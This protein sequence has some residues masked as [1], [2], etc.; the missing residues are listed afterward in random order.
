MVEQSIPAGGASVQDSYRR[1]ILR[2]MSLAGSAALLAGGS[3]APAQTPQHR[4][5][6]A[7]GYLNAREDFR[8]RGDGVADDSTPLQRAIDAGSK[9]VRPIILPPGAYRISRPLIIPPNTMLLG[10][11]PG[12]GFGCRLEPAGCAALLIGGSSMTF[13]CSIENLMIWPRGEP[14]ESIVSIDNSYSVTFRNIRIHNTQ[15]A[16]KRAAVVLLGDE[17]AGGHGRCNDII[18]DNLIVRNDVEQSRLG[19]LATRGCGTHRF[20][21][22]CLENFVTLFEWQGGQI[23]VFAPYTER[24]GRYAVDCNTD[25]GDQTAYL[26]TH[27]GIVDCAESGVACAIRSNSGLFNSFGTAWGARS[28][29]AMYAYSLPIRPVCFHGIEPNLRSSGQGQFAG[30]KGWQRAVRFPQYSIKT[31]TPMA[32]KLTPGQQQASRLH[33]PGV[34]PG[35]YWVRALMDVDLAGVHLSAYVCTEDT[36]EILTHNLSSQT[37]D[38]RGTLLIECGLA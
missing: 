29:R 25:P 12:L 33:V 5:A 23:D 30:V 35:E 34:A 28:S 27:G 4:A 38:V 19:I 37:T 2:S 3:S 22:P 18:W 26:N 17:S 6:Q 13:H 16:V 9:E 24:A 15:Q 36:V 21:A 14:P 31:S 20:I 32:V 11:A 1:S 10:S 7:A 8:A